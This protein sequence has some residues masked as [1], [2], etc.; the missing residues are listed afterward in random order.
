[1][2]AAFIK[3]GDGTEDEGGAIGAL[4]NFRQMKFTEA[5]LEQA[6]IEG[7]GQE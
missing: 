3:E 6:F 2:Y 4:E 5:Q 7:L 1:M